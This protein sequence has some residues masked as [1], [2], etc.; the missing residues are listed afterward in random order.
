MRLI[1]NT[2]KNPLENLAFDEAMIEWAENQSENGGTGQ[3]LLRL[4][5]MPTPCVIL[6]RASK[7]D[8][9]VNHTACEM[10]G[11]PVFRRMSGGATVVAG[12]GCLMYSLLLSYESRPQLRMLDRAHAEVMQRVRLACQASLKALDLPGEIQL[13]GTCDLTLGNRKFSGNALRCK[14]NWLLYHGTILIAMPLDWLGQFLLEP[15]R[16]PEYREKRNHLDFVTS[17]LPAHSKCSP[18]AFRQVLEQ[19]LA[20]QWGAYVVDGE[21]RFIDEIEALEQQL[22]ETRYDKDPWHRGS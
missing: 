21:P 22:M 17:L 11:I 20:I 16:Q 14:R 19:Q 18:I 12:P 7:W 4:W 9:E 3:E 13:Q 15:P 8:V 10:K 5:E 1:R 2:R 6:G